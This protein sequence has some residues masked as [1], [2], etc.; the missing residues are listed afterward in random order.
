MLTCYIQRQGCFRVEKE[1]M[2]NFK[3]VVY[4]M[5]VHLW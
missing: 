1:Y 4:H 3:S 5:S 2:L